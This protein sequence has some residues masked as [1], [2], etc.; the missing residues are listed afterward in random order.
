KD[1]LHLGAMTVT[2]RT[3]GEGLEGAE[4]HDD[5]VIRQ[6]HD[7]LSAEGGLA[8]LRGNLA[9]GGC[10][11]KTTAASPELLLHTGKAVV[12]ENVDDMQQRIDDEDLEV[13]AGSVLVLRNGGPLGGPGMPEWG[14]LPIPKKL[15]AAG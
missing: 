7:P 15:L 5:R 11:I 8:V 2:G 12:F 9:P 6:P 1:S 13:D 4:V 10:V 3:L 14:M